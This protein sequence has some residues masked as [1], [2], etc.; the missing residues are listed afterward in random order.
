MKGETA[1]HQGE[2]GFLAVKQRLSSLAR[3]VS[4]GCWGQGAH[5]GHVA[6]LNTADTTQIDSFLTPVAITT[7][8]FQPPS[9][10]PQPAIRRR[11]LRQPESQPRQSHHAPPDGGSVSSTCFRSCAVSDATTSEWAGSW[12]ILSFSQWLQR[13]HT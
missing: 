13:G 6:A 8:D 9:T 1:A 12:T 4:A 2:A 11:P 5:G 7:T 10:F 3:W